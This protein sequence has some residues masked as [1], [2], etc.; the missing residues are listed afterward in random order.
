M[1]ILISTMCYSLA[2]TDCI[3]MIWTEQSF[4]TEE[5]CILRRDEVVTILPP[6]IVYSYASCFPVPGQRS[7]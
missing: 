1:W 6:N 5:Q 7:S 3:P 2:A 4:L